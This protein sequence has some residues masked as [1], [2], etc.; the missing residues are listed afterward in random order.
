MKWRDW[1]LLIIMV[2]LGYIAVRIALL[3]SGEQQLP[4][5]QPM[6][7]PQPTFERA[8]PSPDA[9]VVVPSSTPRP[10]SVPVPTATQSPTALPVATSTDTPTQLPPSPTVTPT[11]EIVSHTVAGGENLLSIAQQYNTTV[12]A[13]VEANDIANPDLIFIGQELIIPVSLEPTPTPSA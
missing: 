3:S 10:T 4:A 5:S 11:V 9:R 7:T 1:Q 12:E 6:R 8:L 2:L 13:I